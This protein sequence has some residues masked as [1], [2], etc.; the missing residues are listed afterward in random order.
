MAKLIYLATPYSHP[1]WEVKKE[2]F[3]AA[4]RKAGEMMAKGMYVFCPIAHSHP[5][6][7]YS[8]AHP[9]EGFWWLD[10]DFA[11][12]ERCDELCVFMMDGWDSSYGVTEEIKFAKEN[13]IPITYLEA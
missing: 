8:F 3:K 13:G 9:K 5:I 12:L 10:Q 11:V 4:S 7:T 2:R 6:D 1:E